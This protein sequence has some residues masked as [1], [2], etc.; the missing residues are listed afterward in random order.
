M[1][2]CET[3][4]GSE[5]TLVRAFPGRVPGNLT[6]DH[7]FANGGQALVAVDPDRAAH[8]LP[9]APPHSNTASA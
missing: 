8:G 7:T 3:A 2:P 4:R 1:G 5:V 9:E 6:F